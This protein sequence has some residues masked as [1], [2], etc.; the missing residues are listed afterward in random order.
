MNLEEYNAKITTLQ[1]QMAVSEA[2]QKQ[3]I[4]E[5]TKAFSTVSA[6]DIDKAVQIDERVSF[7]NHLDLSNKNTL[8][9]SKEEWDS[10][11]DII[12]VFSAYMDEQ[13]KY[14]EEAFS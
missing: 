1:K 13:I 6:E 2:K 3:V 7:L 11:P 9:L 12:A 10:L 14:F 4:E 5:L 8:G